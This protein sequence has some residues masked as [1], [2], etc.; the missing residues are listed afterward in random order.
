MKIVNMKEWNIS[1]FYIFPTII[2]SKS[3][4]GTR[5]FIVWLYFSIE[6]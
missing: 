2:V 4:M 6:L 3:Y 1:Q 5:V